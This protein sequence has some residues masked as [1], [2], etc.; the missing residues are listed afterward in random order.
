MAEDIK[1]ATLPTETR[2]KAVTEGSRKKQTAEA[3][4]EEAV[5]GCPQCR[6]KV[7]IRNA[8]SSEKCGGGSG[9]GGLE[10]LC[11]PWDRRAGKE[12]QLSR[13]SLINEARE[14]NAIQQHLYWI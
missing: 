9:S 10:E 3:E 4:A 1:A 14:Q 5:N 2:H 8:G 11:C 6:C 7:G 13:I 12:H